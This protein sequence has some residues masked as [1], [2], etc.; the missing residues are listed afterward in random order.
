MEE[1]EREKAVLIDVLKQEVIEQ[2]KAIEKQR[3]KAKKETLRKRKQKKLK[4]QKKKALAKGKEE[5]VEEVGNKFQEFSAAFQDRE[6][7]DEEGVHAGVL[8]QTL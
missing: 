6:K 1:V 3:L 4:E 8:V 2:Q 7:Y 5:L